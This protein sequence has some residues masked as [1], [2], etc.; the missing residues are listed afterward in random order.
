MEADRCHI[1]PRP[2][3][4]ESPAAGENASWW[5]C[6]RPLIMLALVAGA[7]VIA[8][9]VVGIDGPVGVARAASR[10]VPPCRVAFP[11]AR[12]KTIGKTTWHNRQESV[13]Q[14]LCYHF[15]LEPSA[16]FPVTSSMVCGMLAQVIGKGSDR[17]GVFADGACS[18][19]DLADDPK[20]PVKYLSAACS[21]AS[22]VLG[23]LVK[24]AGVLGSIGCTLAPS[25]GHA[26]GGMFESKH[27]FDVAVDVIRHGKCIKYSPSHFGSPWL[28]ERCADGDKGF[29][30]LPV[31]RPGA[32]SVPPAPGGAPP[33][34]APGGGPTPGP[35]GEGGGPPGVLVLNPPS[36]VN[37][38]SLRMEPT[39]E[40]PS[41]T[42]SVGVQVVSPGGSFDPTHL[43]EF[44][45]G[46][47]SW[48]RLSFEGT[49]HSPLAVGSYDLLA[50]CLTSPLDVGSP[51]YIYRAPMEV[52]E[53]PRTVTVQP[54]TVSEGGTITITPDAPCAG[55]L[56][57]SVD[58]FVIRIGT[59][60]GQ[61]LGT[62]DSSC[63]W[64]PATLTLDPGVKVG[65]HTVEVFVGNIIEGPAFWYA[66]TEI[67]VE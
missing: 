5:R 7:L 42:N 1:R 67:T 45:E 40:C 37:G 53:A 34:A 4:R 54:T 10:P 52:S 61:S 62:V 32:P 59:A 16:D 44:F 23:V 66:P 65:K 29:S 6:S 36:I 22:D 31:H 48:P 8:L 56:G 20:E 35:V 43:V 63:S 47:D 30:T 2:I 57:G 33:G 46:P 60:Y 19:A 21:W 26:L 41:G 58:A 18:G 49:H 50:A 24:P 51:L 15:G 25:A 3:A 14:V 12:Q 55:L 17:L 27:E 13:R 11:D 38:Q 39:G 9:P 28:A 64:G